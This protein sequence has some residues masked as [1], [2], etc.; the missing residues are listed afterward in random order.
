MILIQG[1]KILLGEKIVEGNITIEGNEI[2]SIGEKKDKSD[3]VIDAR[4]LAAIP[5]LFNCHTHAAMTMFRG[6][7]ED[8]PLQEWLEK[9]IWPAE[10]R[11]NEKIVYLASKLAC[12]EMLKSGTTFFLDMYF[13]PS[14]T[15]RAVE[16]TGIRA[17]LSSAFFDF[18][19]EEILETSMKRVEKELKELENFRVMRA[20]APHAVYTVSME[21]LRR[22]A[23]MAGR[24]DVFIHFHLAE[25]EKEVVEFRK[26]Y[27]KDIVKALDEIGF[28]SSRLFCAHSVWLEREEIELLARRKVNAI[29]CPTSNMKLSVGKAMNYPEMK[30]AGVNVLLGTDGAASNNS[31]SIFNEMKFCAL[32]Q[33]FSY[34]AESFKA[35]EA[36][37]MATENAGKAF[38]IKAGRIEEGW[39]ADIVLVD[40]NQV[41]FSPCHDLIANL[42]YSNATVDTVIVD[43][44][45]V[46]EGGYFDGEEKLLE[47]FS[48]EVEKFFM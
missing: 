12:V 27:G 3:V 39:L 31:L 13:F 33:K 6:Y 26:K 44:K 14:A 22:S 36:F 20:I 42:V 8:M 37:K 23:E 29:H 32:L 43:G 18:F 35:V 15:A 34:G 46:V 9:K 11:L 40:L 5:G 41:Q 30:K 17:C 48:K 1:A 38:G 45:I 28:L 4:G 21:G 16:E 24:E 2:A 19:S 10:M 47:E 25:T 7:A